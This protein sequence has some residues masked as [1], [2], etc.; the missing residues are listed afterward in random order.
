MDKELKD[1]I[2]IRKLK[3]TQWEVIEMRTKE[4]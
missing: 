1:E 2:H 4:D 3:E